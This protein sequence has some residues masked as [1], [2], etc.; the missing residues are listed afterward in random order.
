MAVLCCCWFLQQST[1]SSV[2]GP[3]FL[4][5]FGD[6]HGGEAMVGRIDAQLGPRQ[7]RRHQLL[8]TIRCLGGGSGF[9]RS[10]CSG[11]WRDSQSA[12]GQNPNL[13]YNVHLN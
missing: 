13:A 12:G 1:D 8:V 10:E 9:C 4:C 6:D 3:E 11:N 2:E 7:L 5:F